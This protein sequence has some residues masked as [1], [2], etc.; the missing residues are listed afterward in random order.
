MLRLLMWGLYLLVQTSCSSLSHGRK[1]VNAPIKTSS[2]SDK[3]TLC[4]RSGPKGGAF[5][6][7][8]ESDQVALA[9][10]EDSQTQS[11]RSAAVLRFTRLVSTTEFTLTRIF[12]VGIP[13]AN[14]IAKPRP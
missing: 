6:R 11:I 14:R 9:A 2:T 4:A 1:G 7:S 12:N 3:E 5:I 10:V 13:F 8:A